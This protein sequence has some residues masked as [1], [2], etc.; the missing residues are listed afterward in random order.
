M[1]LAIYVEKNKT[2]NV[3]ERFSFWGKKAENLEV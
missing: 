1:K 3:L 2:E